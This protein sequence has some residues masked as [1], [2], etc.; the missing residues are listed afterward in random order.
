MR[1][2]LGATYLGD[3]R[4]QFLVWAPM[5]TSV[6]VHLVGAGSRSYLPMDPK[7][8]GY[9]HLPAQ[10]VQPGALYRYRI[11]GE[12]ELPDPASRFQPQGVHGP[13]QIV[14]TH[15]SWTDRGWFGL[16]LQRYVLYELHIGTFTGEGTFDAVIPHLDRLKDLG[17][18]AIELMPVAQ[19]PGRRNWGYDGVYPFAVQDSYGGPDGLKRLVDACHSRGMAAVLDVV[20]NHLGPEGNYF[21]QLGLYFT[22]RYR[23]PWGEAINFDGPH[24]DEVRRFFIENALYWIREFHFDA[25][26]LDAVHAIVDHTAYPFLNE[27]ADAVHHLAHQLNR[28]IYAIPESSLNDVRLIQSKELGGFNLDA[29]W[30]DDFHHSLH[31]L[32]TGERSGYYADFGKLDDLAKCLTEGYVYTGQYSTFRKRRHGSASRQVPAHR[33]VVCAQNHD[34]A[35]NRRLGER[36][37]QLVS[38]E[39]LKLAAACVILSPNVPLL[40]MGEEYGETAP[41]LYFI[42]HSDPQLIEAVRRGRREEFSSF[43]WQDELPDPQAEETFHRSKLTHELREQNQHRILFELHKELLRCRKDH[44]ALAHLSKEDLDVIGFEKQKLLCVRRWNG[45]T[46][47]F[48]AFCFSDAQVSVSVGLPAGNW[49]KLLDSGDQRWLGTGSAIPAELNSE[50]EVSLTLQPKSFVLF[51]NHVQNKEA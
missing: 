13:S 25:L 41:F 9:F 32:L 17:I 48:A 42:D 27:L 12:R 40:F 7:P 47:A 38:F 43:Q 33:F 44:S 51:S 16:P 35:G 21:S 8:G 3:G 1:P 28:Q 30:N 10:G 39:S 15:F 45:S 14:D 22:K 20:Y 36:L 24:S 26:R 19:F 49:H 37:S 23:T 18:T 31:T 11:D 4:S 5:A 6:E 29:Q 34:Q 2:A 50:G 46:Q